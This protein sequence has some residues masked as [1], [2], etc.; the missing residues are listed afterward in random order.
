M[1]FYIR[2]ARREM[3][4]CLILSDSKH[5]HNKLFPVKTWCKTQGKKRIGVPTYEGAGSHNYRGEK[6]RFL[7]IPRY[8]V[9]VG[10]LFLSNGRKLPSKLVNS[11]AI[12]MVRVIKS[13]TVDYHTKLDFISQHSWM[14]WNIFTVEA[15]L[16]PT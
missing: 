16:M 11:L 2:V 6:Y 9:D 1:N 15:M 5:N 12:Q 14:L 8:G 13:N 7:V 10:K 4:E 3:S